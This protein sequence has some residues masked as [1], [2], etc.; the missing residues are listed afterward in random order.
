MAPQQGHSREVRSV[1]T[2][3]ASFD[4]EIGELCCV[5]LTN[6]VKSAQVLTSALALID[7]TLLN[8]AMLILSILGLAIWGLPATL[9]IF[10]LVGCLGSRRFR[11]FIRRHLGV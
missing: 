4:E 3:S 2:R 9:V 10:M 6:C 5:I 1:R 11:G 7:V 8:E